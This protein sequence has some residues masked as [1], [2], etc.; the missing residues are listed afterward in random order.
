MAVCYSRNQSRVTAQH[1]EV[2]LKISM[3]WFDSN[4]SSSESCSP[5]KFFHLKDYLPLSLNLYCTELLKQ[6][7]ASGSIR[8]SCAP[9][10]EQYNT[11]GLTSHELAKSK[12]V[13]LTSYDTA[14]PPLMKKSVLTI[15]GLL[16]RFFYNTSVTTWIRRSWETT[17]ILGLTYWAHL[18]EQNLHRDWKAVL[19]STPIYCFV[20]YS[21]WTISE[22]FASY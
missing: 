3:C 11:F 18:Q 19:Y 14:K 8:G 6:R 13:H 7:A 10:T 5:F 21:K 22:H 9:P 16:W 4:Y 2:T 12:H 15:Y 17:D 1:G 20:G